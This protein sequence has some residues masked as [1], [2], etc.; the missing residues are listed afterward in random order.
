MGLNLGDFF[1]KI[2]TDLTNFK[3]GMKE[4][5]AEMKD[6]EAEIDALSKMMAKSAGAMG[7]A[8]VA[9][10][11]LSVKTFMD[12]G[13][14][15]DKMSKRTGVSVEYLSKLRYV[16]DR[17]GTSLEG[18]ETGMRRLQ[19]AVNDADQGLLEYQ[20]SF[21]QL[22]IDY[23]ALTRESP[24]EQFKAVMYALAGV[25]NASERAALAQDLLGRSG[26]QLIPIIADGTANFEELMEKAEELGIV[27]DEET[28]RKAA[29]LKDSMTSLKM[30][31]QG[32]MREIG[33]GLAPIIKGLADVITKV[34]AGFSKW[35]DAN[36]ELASTISQTAM[37][38]GT[39]MMALSAYV[40][41]GPKVVA[42]AHAIAL[43]MHTSLGP[44]GLVTLAVT[45]LT[46]ALLYF[47]NQ[48]SEAAR[49][50]NQRQ[51]QALEE[52][53]EML[54]KELQYIKDTYA[55]EVEAAEE[56]YGL[57]IDEARI[58]YKTIVEL[59][60]EEVR[61][62]EELG[63]EEVENRLGIAHDLLE[64]A[65]TT[66]EKQEEIALRYYEWQSD[67][68]A[69]NLSDELEAIDDKLKAAQDAYQEQV[70]AANDLYEEEIAL[71][72]ESR[73]ERLKALQ[74]QLDAMDK[75]EIA[76]RKGQIAARKGELDSLLEV[77][78]SEETRQQLLK[79]YADL[80]KELSDIAKQE[81]RDAIQEQMDDIN[82]IAD[83]AIQAS[84]DKKDNEIDDQQAILDNAIAKAEI[85]RAE[86]EA[87]FA[88]SL[89]TLQ[90][91]ILN[92]TPA[93]VADWDAAMTGQLSF[94][95]QWGIDHEARMKAIDDEYNGP[96]GIITNI[97]KAKE[98]DLAAIEETKNAKI[99]ANADVLAAV[100]QALNQM[101]GAAP[102][103]WS[104]IVIGQTTP[105]KP[106][107][108]GSG[109]YGQMY[110]GGT[111]K[112]KKTG[113]ALVHEGE[114]VIPASVNRLFG[115]KA[116]SF[117][118][119]LQAPT[120]PALAAAPA[121]S[122]SGIVSGMTLNNY[123]TGP[124]AGT[125][126]DAEKFADLLTPALRRKQI[127]NTGRADW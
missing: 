79:E 12:V 69:E 106:A 93:E 47:W 115:N 9:F 96:E 98:A 14:Q 33:E 21:E 31:T 25:T 23:S 10:G 60:A 45:A 113:M 61:L 90:E 118:E 74:D 18:F 121:V 112:I 54:E 127:A 50:A 73:D 114:S 87:N 103:T 40:L 70:K 85:A 78:R 86:A 124:F 35:A 71:I 123:F 82:T 105:Q 89:A 16:A 108:G 44:L 34:T 20:R 30:S 92:F 17:A 111:D 48:S 117:L 39:L 59:A 26:T 5:S 11:T 101:T 15:L 36:P 57:L 55:D 102:Q 6:K 67:K 32:V 125:P 46:A 72:Q 22:G 104:D 52:R 76:D 2:G 29:A 56:K 116:L 19:R 24:E 107:F 65:T 120:L 81:R 1:V 119:G 97:A 83:A 37:V 99:K 38:M 62:K 3:A 4:M 110:Q 66:V 53:R 94:Q 63:K 28:A 51:R 75:T 7:A 68:L 58:A 126:A 49:K 88:A 95:T 100:D 64:I 13:D 122:G 27:M 41:I 42:A 43:A 91:K 77:V 109:N 84:E 80:D 8:I